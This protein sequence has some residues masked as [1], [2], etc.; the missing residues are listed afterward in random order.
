MK[1][2]IKKI[3]HKKIIKSAKS[4]N[5]I[6]K[7]PTTFLYKITEASLFENNS[8]IKIALKS[9]KNPYFMTNTKNIILIFLNTPKLNNLYSKNA[10]PFKLK[11][12]LKKQNE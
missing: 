7:Q 1:N 5:R 4:K 2:K 3:N 8:E 10:K 6:F 9:F 12:I 11:S